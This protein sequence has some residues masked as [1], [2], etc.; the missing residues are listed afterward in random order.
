MALN[1]VKDGN[2]IPEESWKD[3]ISEMENSFE[4]LET[5]LERAKREIAKILI[6][7]VKKRVSPKFGILF[8]GGVDS[9]LIAFICK[10]LKCNFTC[11]TVGIESSDD[12]E[13]AGKIAKEYNLDWKHKVFSLDEY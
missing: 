7:A 9:T 13:W 6:E 1:F 8:S 5:N 11:Y 3:M 10:Q 2:L 4:N 12:I